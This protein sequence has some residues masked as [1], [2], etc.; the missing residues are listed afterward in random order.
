LESHSMTLTDPDSP[1]DQRADQQPD[2]G[3]QIVWLV[4]GLV[5][6]AAV[7][8]LPFSARMDGVVRALAAACGITL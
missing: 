4:W 6:L 1:E 3:M 8:I 7:A 5:A 2:K